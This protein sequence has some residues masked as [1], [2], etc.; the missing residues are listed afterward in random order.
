MGKR[1]VL[2]VLFLGLLSASMLLAQPNSHGVPLVSNYPHDIT[3]GGEQNWC[4]TQD[5]RGVIYVG[6]NDKG[7]LEYDGVEWRRIAIPNDPSVRSMVLGDDGLVYVGAVSEFGYL[8]PDQVGNM[9]YRSLSDSLDRELYPFSAIWSTYSHEGLVYFCSFNYI[10][11]YDLAAEQ[12]SVLETMEFSFYSFLI[13]GRLYVS[14]YGE[15]LM[16]FEEDRQVVLPGGEFFREMTITGIVPFDDN[17]FLVGTYFNGLYLY[18]LT[19]GQVDGAFADQEVNDYLVESNITSIRSFREAFVVSSMAGGVIILERNGQASAIISENEGLIDQ[20]VPFVFFNENISGSSPLWITNFMGISKLEPENPFRVFTEDSGFEDFITDIQVFNGQL[21]ISTFGGVYYRSSSSTGTHFIR[22]PVTRGAFIRHL[23]LFRPSPGREYLLASSDEEVYVID[24][25]MNTR[26][27]GDLVVNLPDDPRDRAEYAGP[28]LLQDPRRTDRLFVGR[29][30]VVG[31]QYSRGRWEEFMRVKGLVEHEVMRKKCID[32]HDFFWGS[33]DF[34]VNRVDIKNPSLP[35]PKFFDTGSG[36]PS[37][38]KNLVFLNPETDEV[39]F[40]TRD[41][42][43]RYDYFRDTIVRDTFFNHILPPGRNQIMAFHQDGDGEYWFSFENAHNQWT[44]L[45]ARKNGDHLEIVEEK[46]FQRLANV[47]VDVFYSD[48]ENKLWFGKSNKLYHFNKEFSRNDSV[49]FQALI[50]SVTIGS[51]SL[52]YNGAS[53]GEEN[54]RK[55]RPHISYKFNNLRFTWAAPF[56]EQEKEIEYSYRL[57]GFEDHWAA[58]STVPFKE[59]TNL[60]YGSYSLELKAR[61]VYGTESIPALWSFTILRPWYAKFLAFLIYLVLAVL[62][63]FVIIKLYT[64]RLKME[65]LRLEEVILERTAEIRKQKEEL[66]DSIEYASRIQRALL[67]SQLLLDQ[68]QIEN[69]IL[70]KPRDIVSGDFY[71]IGFRNDKLVVV[72]ADCTGH[73]VPGAFMSMLG[74]TFLDEIVIK[75]E[76]TSTDQILEELR[77]HVITALKQTG[78]S[79]DESKDGMDLALVSLDLKN[80]EFQFSGA[81]NPVYLVRKLKRS[82][83]TR[84]N[85]GQELNVPRGAIYNDNYL[86]QPIRADQMPI[87]ISEKKLPFGSI[88]FKNEGYNIY[89]FSD[90]FLDQFGGPRGKKFMSKNFKKLILELQSL[91]LGKQGEAMEKVLNDWMGDISQ[92]DDILVMGLRMKEH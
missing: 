12:F 39:L 13:D 87:G 82:E 65:N 67:P 8:A 2:T 70:F 11:I 66:T 64:R 41:G 53:M 88:H 76:I 59:F 92:I 33:A 42:F 6:N 17:S 3:L 37:R 91:P 23:L 63:V 54:P 85:K 10:F 81:Y 32:K 62:L 25:Q 24:K 31:I 68:H 73:G 79:V 49:S 34:M 78:K 14:D 61:N 74:M 71:W 57:S 90:G 51:D 46:A 16:R 84:I 86:L 20:Q 22:V 30:Q 58:W 72:A 80:Q 47:S 83:K 38:D 15:G 89:M 75:S 9:Q 27:L 29:S 28:S 45:L 56:F 55:A 1:S 26:L 35:V 44:E 77:K 43:Y 7:I 18:N 19:S 48:P 52:I 5:R 69:F 50:R 21:F 36:L 4:I 60:P 40:G